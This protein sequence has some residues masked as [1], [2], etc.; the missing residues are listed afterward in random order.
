MIFIPRNLSVVAPV[1]LTEGYHSTRRVN[2]EAVIGGS[3]EP[4]EGEPDLCIVKTL[5]IVVYSI[6]VSDIGF[7]V[8]LPRGPDAQQEA[9]D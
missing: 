3:L 5:S 7:A 4:L 6:A 1:V 2:S 8:C 9:S